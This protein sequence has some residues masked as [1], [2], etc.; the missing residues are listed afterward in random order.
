MK[1][2]RRPK[3]ADLLVR[4]DAIAQQNAR[5]V[6]LFERLLGLAEKSA[7]V[8]QLSGVEVRAQ[9]LG[10][11]RGLKERNENEMTVSEA[12][13]AVG[14]CNQQIRNWCRDDGIG[15][16]RDGENRWVVFRDRLSAYAKQR[17]GDRIRI[18]A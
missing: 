10:A 6:A 15:E 11:L 16:F 1:S 3:L 7:L 17:F 14:R 5:L 2:I 12:A 13:M 9:S 18:R 4:L 8:D